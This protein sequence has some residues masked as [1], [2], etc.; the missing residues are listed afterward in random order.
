M[1]DTKNIS[2]SSAI[3]KQYLFGSK[4]RGNY[5]LD[6]LITDKR[7]STGWVKKLYKGSIVDSFWSVLSSPTN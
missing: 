7:V 4:V 3:S 1:A 5:L 2:K 6:N